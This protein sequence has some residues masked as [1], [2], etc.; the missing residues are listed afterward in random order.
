[1]GWKHKRNKMDMHPRIDK[2]AEVAE[3][4]R[5]QLQGAVPV[6]HRAPALEQTRA[7]TPVSQSRCTPPPPPLLRG[8]TF[9]DFSRV[10]IGKE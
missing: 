9:L 7:G 8:L 1:M 10:R 5:G 3:V 2:Q 6:K 4:P